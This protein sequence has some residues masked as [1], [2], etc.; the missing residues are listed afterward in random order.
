MPQEPQVIL[1][2]ATCILIN[3]AEMDSQA[4]PAQMVPQHPLPRL[5]KGGA[6]P[7]LATPQHIPFRGPQLPHQALTCIFTFYKYQHFRSAPS[8]DTMLSA[9]VIPV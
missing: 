1:G 5:S 2:R 7:R 4:E 3:E 6:S 8:D 9:G